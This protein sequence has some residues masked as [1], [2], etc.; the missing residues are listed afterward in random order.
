MITAGLC[1]CKNNSNSQ[2]DTT[3]SSPTIVSKKV[4]TFNFSNLEDKIKNIEIKSFS[5]SDKSIVLPC[6]VKT[7][8]DLGYTISSSD[9]DTKLLHNSYTTI[10]LKNKS[11][12]E[13]Y[14]TLFNDDYV[15]TILKDTKVYGIGISTESGKIKANIQ[16]LKITSTI[17]EIT[18]ELGK[19]TDYHYNIKTETLELDYKS[20]NYSLTFLINNNK[21]SKLTYQIHIN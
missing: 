11:N 6:S 3:V 7:F 4:I 21:C 2:K 12:E 14:L 13:I 8:T 9:N 20:D 10:T 5:L 18:K 1:S 19:P 17:D 16:N 15:P